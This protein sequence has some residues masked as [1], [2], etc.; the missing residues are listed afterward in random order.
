M[1]TGKLGK[2]LA[3]SLGIVVVSVLVV[4][5][6]TLRFAH[7]DRLCPG[8]TVSGVPVGGM[9]KDEAARV[10]REWAQDRVSRNL[11]LT[12]LDR[13]WTGNLASLG[14]RIDWPAAIDKACAVGREGNIVQRAVC[15][16]SSRGKGKSITA[17]PLVDADRLGKTLRK[18]ASAVNR[19]HTDARLAVVDDR[20]KVQQDAS[21]IKLDQ[22]AAARVVTKAAGTARNV[23][24]LPIVVDPPDVT[25]E[26]CAKINTRLSSFT[27]TFNPATRG[28]THNLTLAARAINGRV[29][30]PGQ[31][32]SVNATVG[33][34]LAGRGYRMA[35]VFIKGQLVDGIGGGVCQV[36]STLFNAVLLAGLKVVERHPH[37]ETVPYVAP[38]RDATV[39]WGF[40]DFRFRNN[41]SS[42]VAIIA[43]VKG[44]RLT[45]QV[46]GAAEDKKEVKV[47]TGSI[48][49]VPAGVVTITDAALA[50]GA[51]KTVE[52]GISGGST[53]LYRKM[54]GQDGKEVVDAY[55]SRY[56]PHNAVIAVGGSPAVASD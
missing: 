40:K 54:I 10:V 44:S 28:R 33:P 8:I 27:T 13:R 12:A 43:I 19:P 5:T 49:R 11:T 15:V 23:V 7:T 48:K 2:L 1:L 38:G 47:Y 6:I 31:E 25:A 21:G 26:D 14:L 53:V 56:A 16:L 36:S 41:S 51:R 39:A 22:E 46:Y 4:L 24:Q 37:P 20:L 29:I 42:P 18:V 3:V 17:A 9:S 55:R 32:F 52:K 30:K 45:V 35:Q 34:R 50:P